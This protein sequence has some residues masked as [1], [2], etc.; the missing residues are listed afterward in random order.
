MRLRRAEDVAALTALGAEARHLAYPDAVYRTDQDGQWLYTSEES[1]WEPPHAQDVLAQ[2]GAQELANELAGWVA[3]P[4][5]LIYAP[6]GAGGHVDHRITH[7]AAR[8]LIGQGCR[9]AFYEEFPYAEKPGATEAAIAAAGGE[10]WDGELVKVTPVDVAA[11]VAALAYYRT[12]MK[13]L[14]GGIE[15][16]PSR[17]WAFA[18]SRSREAEA[19]LAERLWWLTDG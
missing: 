6:L 16:M 12:Q 19:G 9:I 14:F 2:Q 10:A 7:A 18:A 3:K 15:T 8:R 5:T 13:V 4:D 17:V 11:K 1:I